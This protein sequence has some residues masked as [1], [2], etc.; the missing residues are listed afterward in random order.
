MVTVRLH[1]RLRRIVVEV[2]IQLVIAFFWIVSIVTFLLVV[3]CFVV[4]LIVVSIS[5]LVGAS[6][7]KPR[8]GEVGSRLRVQ[9]V[10]A[11]SQRGGS[12]FGLGQGYEPGVGATRIRE[13]ATVAGV[14]LAGQVRCKG[15]FCKHEKIFNNRQRERG[16]E[17]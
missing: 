16:S 1:W 7:L 8:R 5:A 14:H 2:V 17:E 6:V 13:A 12:R 15:G 4:V 11:P 3:E 10:Q 9:L